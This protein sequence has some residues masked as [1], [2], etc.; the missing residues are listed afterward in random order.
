MTWAMSENR[1]VRERL[2]RWCLGVSLVVLATAGVA[3]D[4]DEPSRV[5]CPG[6]QN[7]TTCAQGQEC[8]WFHGVN[9]YFCGVA[10]GVGAACSANTTCKAGAAS[11]CMTCRD[12]HRRLRVTPRPRIRG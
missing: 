3:C 9:G 7:G 5:A 11:S 12:H 1:D 2:R 4:D 10:C 8:L 6:E